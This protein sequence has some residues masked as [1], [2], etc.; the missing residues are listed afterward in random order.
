MGVLYILDEYSIGLNGTIS[1]LSARCISSG[2]RKY[3]YC[4]GDDEETMFAA[5]HIIHIG[6]RA[7]EHGGEVIAEEH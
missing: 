7:G 4:G 6:H 1:G 3:H 2:T 5:D